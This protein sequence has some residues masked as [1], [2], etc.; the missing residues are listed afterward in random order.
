M[1]ARELRHFF[2]RA[3][4]PRAQ[5]EINALA[6][7]CARMLRAVSPNLFEGTGPSCLYG[8]CGEGKM[9]CGIPYKPEDVDAPV[10]ARRVR[11]DLSGRRSGVRRHDRR[12]IQ[13]AAVPIDARS[14]GSLRYRCFAARRAQVGGQAVIEGV[15]MRGVRT[16]VAGGA[17]ARRHASACTNSPW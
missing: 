7:A 9:T 13:N 14:R 15:M 10:T 6:W 16:L 1:N 17:P 8:D 11:P 3:L 4:L 5:W 2:Q 12:Q